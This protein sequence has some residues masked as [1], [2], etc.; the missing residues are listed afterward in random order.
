[1]KETLFDDALE[2]FKKGSVSP[3][4][5]INLFEEFR[6]SMPLNSPIKFENNETIPESINILS[7]YIN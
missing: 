4:N 5:L 2:Y 1:M 7:K 3:I 6:I